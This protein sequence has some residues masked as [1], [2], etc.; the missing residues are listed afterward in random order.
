MYYNSLVITN[1]EAYVKQVLE[2][3]SSGHDWWHI[4][5]VQN[6]AK[7][8]QKSEGGNLYIIELSAL[9]HDIADWKFHEKEEGPKKARLFLK[10]QKM[11]NSIIDSVCEIIATSSFKGAKVDSSMKTIEGEILQDADRLDA[12]GAVGI[13]RCFTYGGN[14]NKAIYDPRI[15]PTLHDNAEA[16]KNN[17]SSTI[18][19]FYEKLLLLKDLM[20]TETGKKIAEQRHKFME[21]FLEQF[22][23]EWKGKK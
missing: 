6:L 9:L 11:E 7:E 12:I 8:I 2:K 3:D 23:E 22:F 20:N 10:T 5:R 4:Y 15:K 17:D 19:H 21:L 18:N 16:Y 14:Q 13:A 1:T